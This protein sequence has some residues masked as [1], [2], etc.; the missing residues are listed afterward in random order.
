M[1]ADGNNEE[2]NNQG[3]ILRRLIQSQQNGNSG[4]VLNYNIPTLINEF[5]Q[6]IYSNKCFPISAMILSVLTFFLAYSV[7]KKDWEIELLESE[8]M[9]FIYFLIF[10]IIAILTWNFYLAMNLLIGNTRYNKVKANVIIFADSLYFNPIIFTF[11]IYYYDRSFLQTSFDILFVLIITTHYYTI[12]YFTINLFKH[13]E[14][15]IS[16]ITNFMLDENKTLLLRLRINFLALGLCNFI[17]SYFVKLAVKETDFMY[18][19]FILLKG[20]YLFLKQVECLVSSEMR[21]RELTWSTNVKEDN[22]LTPLSVKTKIKIMNMVKL[23][24]I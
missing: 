9:A 22:I 1:N 10:L 4:E 16:Q 11:M 14:F 12:F 17:F 18:K 13:A 15:K 23:S 24:F 8:E 6:V 5:E 19:Y 7:K 2:N 21:Y 3:E 20:V